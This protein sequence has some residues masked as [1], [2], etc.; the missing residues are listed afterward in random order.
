MGKSGC[1]HPSDVHPN[2]SQLQRFNFPQCLVN[3]RIQPVPIFLFIGKTRIPKD[4]EWCFDKAQ[5]TM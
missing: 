5:H 1:M 4:R 3:R 2:P